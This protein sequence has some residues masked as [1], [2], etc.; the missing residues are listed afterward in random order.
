LLAATVDQIEESN[1]EGETQGEIIACLEVVAAALSQSSLAPA[2]RLLWAID[3]DMADDYGTCIGLVAAAWEAA[4]AE[5]CRELAGLLQ[6]RLNARNR[7][8]LPG[9]GRGP[10]ETTGRASARGRQ[11]GGV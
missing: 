2:E 1:D 9:R 5:A 10:L 8:H 6:A 7:G 11:A 4:D 3:R